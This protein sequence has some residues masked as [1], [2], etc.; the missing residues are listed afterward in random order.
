MKDG[1][2]GAMMRRHFAMA[3][4]VSGALV[5]AGCGMHSHSGAPTSGTSASSSIYNL[6]VAESEAQHLLGQ[7]RLP[8]DAKR[9][10]HQPAGTAPRLSSYSVSVPVVPHLVDRHEFYVASGTPASVIG[11]AQNH[12]PLGSRQDD[13]GDADQGA[14]WTSF[15]FPAIKGFASSPDLLL[16]AV[17]MRGGKVAIRVDA[18]V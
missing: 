6:Q 3:W 17:P 15:S 5:V 14:H 18:Q 13:N 10:A 7:V 16:D 2:G 1:M 11:W 12:R 9:S 4:S 8:P